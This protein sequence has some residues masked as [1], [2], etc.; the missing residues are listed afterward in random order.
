MQELQCAV[1]SIA[2]AERAVVFGEC[3]GRQEFPVVL[4]VDD[5]VD[6]AEHDV[7]GIHA[8][9]DQQADLFEGPGATLAV[10]QERGAG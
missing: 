10:R 1:R 6:V 7:P 2:P 5:L 9:V 3:A 8:V 4:A